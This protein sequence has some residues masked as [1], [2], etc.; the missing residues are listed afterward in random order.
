MS[1]EDGYNYDSFFENITEKIDGMYDPDLLW[2]T[3]EVGK[4]VAPEGFK[5][6]IDR[7]RKQD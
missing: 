2:I 6:I 4:Y 5:N 1:F 3:I 7:Y